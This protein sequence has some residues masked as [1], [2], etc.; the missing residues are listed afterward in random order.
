MSGNI[1]TGVKAHDD[2]C[3]TA[4]MTRQVAVAGAATQAAVNAAE[5]VYYKAVRDSARNNGLLAELGAYNTVIRSLNGI[6]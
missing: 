2:A 1:K 6:P 3:Q 5:V 4:E